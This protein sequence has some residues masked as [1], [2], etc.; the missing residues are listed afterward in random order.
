MILI[1]GGGGFLGLNLARHLVD[2]GEEVLLLDNRPIQVP[3]FLAPF[4]DKQAKGVLGDLLDLP[5]LLNVIK[6]HSVDSIIHAAG[7]FAGSIY[8]MLKINLEGTINVLEAGR[9]FRLRRISFIS[10]ETVYFGA[11]A[12]IFHEGLDLP[13]TFPTEV[14]TIKKAGEQICLFY[15]AQHGLSVPILRPARIYGPLSHGRRFPVGVMVDNAIA[16][17]LVD[18]SETYGGGKAVYVYVKDCAKGISLVHLSKALKHNAYNL[19]DDASHS[20]LDFAKAIKEV[21]PDAEFRFGTTRSAKDIDFPDLSI[22]QIKTELGF[23]VDYD[24]KRAVKD[25]INWV[26]DGKY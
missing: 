9:L 16:H 19:G 10:S 1:T 11:K 21:I 5:N 20:Y 24:L 15:A 23:V 18:L 17:K 25:Y 2:R 26:R 14:P 22:E 4:W 6:E 8:Q 3:S 12:A 7:F 13:L